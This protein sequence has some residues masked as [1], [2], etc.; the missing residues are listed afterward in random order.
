MCLAD[1]YSVLWSG[2]F[3]WW[4]MQAGQGGTHSV[5]AFVMLETFIM[6][7][8]TVFLRDAYVTCPPAK[9]Q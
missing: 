2:R 5:G 1:A 3:F 4:G 7:S 9:C 8:M 6:L